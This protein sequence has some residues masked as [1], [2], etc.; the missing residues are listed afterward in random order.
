MNLLDDLISSL[1]MNA[2]VRDVR[3]GV[4]Q[5][6]V[7][8]R[9]CGLASTPHEGENI[10]HRGASSVKYAG[11]LLENDTRTLVNLSKSDSLLEA[12]IGLAA[13]NSLLEVDMHRCREI[14]AA[15]IIGQ[16]GRG[17]N[18]AII[19]HFPFIPKL[20]G[21]V[22]NLWVIEKNPDEGDYPEEA[23]GSLLPEADVIGIT[24]VTLINHTFDEI[25][26]YCRP[27]AFVVMLGGT[28]PLSPV[29][30]DYGIN[31]IAGTLIV[32]PE[33]ALACVSQGATFRQ[34]MGKRL[35]T[36]E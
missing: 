2:V 35:L 29:L 16:K 13:I 7:Y 5:S 14:N 19:G 33:K 24:G 6:A 22:N 36:M 9:S 21:E 30:F 1:D 3:L 34:I 17:K 26:S 15:D 4:F 8:T 23:A 31:A 28:T 18:V 11:N 10:H 20:K 32:E 25:I 12:A 27:E